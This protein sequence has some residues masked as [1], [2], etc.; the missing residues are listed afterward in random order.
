MKPKFTPY[1]YILIFSL[2]IYGVLAQDLKL[3][4]A[5]NQETEQEVLNQFVFTDIQASAENLHFEID[6]ILS[7]LQ[8][9]GYLN[10]RLD[11]IVVLDTLYTAYFSLGKKLDHIKIYYDHIATV[12][13][14]QKDLNPIARKITPSYFEIL[15]QDIQPSMQYLADLFEKKGNSFIKVSLDKIEL[16][17]QEA[18]AVLKIED[19]GERTIDK[20]VVKG[21]EDFPSS[22]IIHEL[23]LKVGSTFNRDKLKLASQAVNNLP[24][25]EEHK[26]PEVL[27]TNDSTLVYLFLKKKKSN[28]F[29]GII[30]FASKEE[31][32]GL[33]FNGYLDL[34]INNIFNSGETIALY[35]KNNGNDR[36]RFYLDAELPYIFNLPLIPKGNFELYRQDTTYSNVT[37][38]LS[39]GY[40]FGSKGLLTAA[41]RAEN[42]N[43]LTNGDL[44]NVKSYSNRFYGLSY[45]FKKMINEPLFP[46][47][48]QFLFDAMLGSRNSEDQ[49]TSQSRFVLQASY[50]YTINNKNFIYAQNQ[51]GLLNSDNYLANE[52][53]RIG[54][55]NNIRGVNEESIFASVYSAFNLEYR[56]KPNATSYFYSISD[57][58]YTEN[59]ID[60]QKTN[61]ISLGLGYAFI[62]KAGVL[63]LNYANGKFD[64]EPFSFQ[65]SKVHVKIISTF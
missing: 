25:A 32:S 63:N 5:A 9:Q 59:N 12:L 40:S 35:W 16:I 28:Q 33:Q 18:T 48:F 21:Y 36:Q 34:S 60:D 17:D 6:S 45:I 26:A 64:N 43:D 42:S 13:L 8:I 24:F 62:T 15:F 37:T 27:F 11:T 46:V 65:N 47:K 29:D 4:I 23:G 50:I 55:V 58:S 19:K 56:F 1:I 22:Y 41:F 20:V 30:G 52:L 39:L 7:K 10:T 44:N 38:H 3:T 31:S 49:D 61:I 14:N 2:N 57:F 51:S 53:F 54:G